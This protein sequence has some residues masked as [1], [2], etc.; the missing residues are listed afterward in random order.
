MA[1]QNPLNISL[2]IR[3]TDA[4]YAR[5]KRACFRDE[6]YVNAFIRKCIT[7]GTDRLIDKQNKDGFKLQEV[8]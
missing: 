2:S 8:L 3:L 7:E 5:T 1:K 6:L 4:E